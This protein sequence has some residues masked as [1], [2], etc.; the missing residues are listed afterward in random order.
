MGDGVKVHYIGT[1]EDGT[2]FDNSYSR[3]KPIAFELGAGRVI[4]GWDEGIALMHVGDKATFR[5]PAELG[6][7]DR[8]VGPIPANA[9]LLFDVEL[10]DVLRPVPYDTTHKVLV[11]TESGLKFYLIEKGPGRQAVAGDRATVHYTGYLP[12]GSIFDSSIT[13]DQ[14]F[15]FVIGMG[16]VIP[17]WDEGVALMHV[18]DKARLEIPTIW[19]MVKKVSRVSFPQSHVDF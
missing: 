5:I 3:N 1:L 4:R 9:T 6:Y 16:K 13:R 12:D 7:G 8:A 2:E 14:V 19:P 18:G 17:G 15:K 10:V 11:T